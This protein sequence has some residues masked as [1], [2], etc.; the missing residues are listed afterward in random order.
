[1]A[2][3]TAE[4]KRWMER[5]AQ[6]AEEHGAFPKHKGNYDFQLHHVRGRTYKHNKV[7]IGHWLILPI[8]TKYHDVNSNNPWN[9]THWP[10]RYAIEFGKQKDQ[11]VAMC[12]VIKEEDNG[13][14][15]GDDVLN[16]IMDLSV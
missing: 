6:Y 4:Q 11:F 13:L 15:F 3:P 8:E 14:P 7:A 2:K 1:M 10:K 12:M 5:I 9:V 16:A